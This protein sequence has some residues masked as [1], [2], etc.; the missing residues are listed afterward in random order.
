[1]NEF[2]T[3]ISQK[4]IAQTLVNLGLSFG[5]INSFATLKQALDFV[6]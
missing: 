3:K 1:M 5:R 2:L 4:T 6:D